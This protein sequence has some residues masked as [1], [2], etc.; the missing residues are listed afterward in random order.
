MQSVQDALA[1]ANTNPYF[2]N[3]GIGN[4][5]VFSLNV[6]YDL[7]IQ[8]RFITPVLVEWLRAYRGLRWEETIEYAKQIR[9]ECLQALYLFSL[10]FKREIYNQ[11]QEIRFVVER[12]TKNNE[13]QNDLF[14]NGSPKV[15]A[16]ISHDMLKG[17][18]VTHK[19][20]ADKRI[21]ELKNIL[22]KNQFNK[23]KVRVTELDY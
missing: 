8:R 7:S 5:Y 15:V 6:I 16:N 12:L 1:E 18:I 21:K 9:M 2:E 10:C 20:N 22:C 13:K 4:A 23:T 3:M 14:F 17:V 11:E 19:N